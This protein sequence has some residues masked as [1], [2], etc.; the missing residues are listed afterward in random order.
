V[1]QS[2]PFYLPVRGEKKKKRV[3]SSYLKITK[4]KRK[5]EILIQI[6]EWAKRKR[7]EKK[8]DKSRQAAILGNLKGE[9]KDTSHCTVLPVF[10]QKKEEGKIGKGSTRIK[11]F[12]G[13]KRKG[14][15]PAT[16]DPRKKEAWF[17]TAYYPK[18]KRKK[19]SGFIRL[20]GG[21]GGKKVSSA[22]KKERGLLTKESREIVPQEKMRFL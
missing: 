9:K 20:K 13:E 5:D 3:R 7:R 16:I 14:S 19:N 18:K 21:G 6:C 10:H 8:K 4:E 17:I 2:S 15:F 1:V 11:P 22:E 12:I